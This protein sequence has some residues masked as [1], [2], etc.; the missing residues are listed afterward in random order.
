LQEYLGLDQYDYV[1][2]IQ[3]PKLGVGHKIDPLAEKFP[4]ISPYAFVANKPIINIDPGDREIIGVTKKDAQNF[5][6]DVY[7]V[8]ADD[9]FANVRALIDLMGKAFKS[10]DGGALTK[11]LDCITLSTDERTYIDMV[12]NIINAKETYK[13]EYVSGDFTSSEGAAAFKDYMNKT[14]P[15]VGGA[16]VTPEGNLSTGIIDRHVDLNVPT[17]GHE[18]FGHGIPAAKGLNSTETTQMQSL[19]INL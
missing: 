12:T 8:L 14:Q 2:R 6:T 4:S 3:D 18:V 19:Q 7:T 10:I 9:K 16:M 11:A 17:L 13:V 15:G 1:A 5:R